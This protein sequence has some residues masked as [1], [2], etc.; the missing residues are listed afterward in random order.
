M[1]TEYL[2]V[3]IYLYASYSNHCYFN[4]EHFTMQKVLTYGTRKIWME[5]D[6]CKAVWSDSRFL[7]S[8]HN[9]GLDKD[10]DIPRTFLMKTSFL[11]LCFQFLSQQVCVCFIFHN[12]IFYRL[13]QQEN[14]LQ[15][16]ICVIT[17]EHRCKPVD[18]FIPLVSTYSFCHSKLDFRIFETF[19]K[20]AGKFWAALISRV[21]NLETCPLGF[22]YM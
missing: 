17:Y 16:G 20:F 21:L 14:G 12:R 9:E 2:F 6:L 13:I 7:F 10:K 8:L 19:V 4:T 18:L 11:F 15:L 3:N 22:I 5:C 1:G